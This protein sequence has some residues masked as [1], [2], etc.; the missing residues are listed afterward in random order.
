MVLEQFD[1]FWSHD[2]GIVRTR[3]K[4]VEQAG[5]VPHAVIIS[6]L[7]RAGKSTLLLQLAHRL[8]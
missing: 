3:L 1:S 6:G 4:E 8:G 5:R 2:L 7:R